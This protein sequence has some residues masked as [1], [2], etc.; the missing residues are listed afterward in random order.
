VLLQSPPP[1]SE[2]KV[3]EEA[4]KTVEMLPISFV[5]LCDSLDCVGQMGRVSAKNVRVAMF[6]PYATAHLAAEFDRVRRIPVLAN[7]SAALFSIPRETSAEQLAKD[8][9][10][11]R[12]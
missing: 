6:A 10:Q 12:L 3:I 11:L 7:N 1:G 4:A 8:I 9:L 2:A 5:M